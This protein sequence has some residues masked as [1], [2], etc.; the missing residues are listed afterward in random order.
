ME[1]WISFS[2]QQVFANVESAIQMF[3]RDTFFLYNKLN[4]KLILSVLVFVSL[5]ISCSFNKEPLEARLLEK[6][7]YD[8]AQIRLKN[9]NF[10]SAILS[11]ETLEARFPFGRYAEQSQAELIFAYYRILNLKLLYLLQR[12]L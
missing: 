12:D 3:I 8:Q 5:L 11:L 1:P 4:G 9:G 10:S 7:L 2:V 6:E